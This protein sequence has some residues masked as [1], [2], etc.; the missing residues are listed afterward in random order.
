MIK[1]IQRELNNND[2]ILITKKENKFYLTNFTGSGG[3]LFISKNKTFF[4]LDGKYINQAKKQTKNIEILNIEGIGFF[5]TFEKLLKDENIKNV[6]FESSSITYSFYELLNKL[7]IKLIPKENIVEN[8]RVIKSNKEIELI[9]QSCKVA[10]S[11]ILNG[12][13]SFKSGM[14][15]KELAL[16]I[17][18]N[19]RLLNADSIDFIIVASGT[20]GSQPHIRPTDKKIN[21]GEFVTIDFG[22]VYS[23]YHSD[24]TRTFLIG[25]V[26]GV[27]KNIYQIVYEA[28]QLGISLV[29][30]GAST[31]YIDTQV[32]EFISEKGYG[33]YFVHGLG[34][35]IGING[36]EEPFLNQNC[37]TIL[38]ENMTLTIEPG[39][40]IDGVGGVRIEDT[41]VVTENGCET[42][43]KLSKNMGEILNVK[44]L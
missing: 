13:K 12:L 24:V 6:Y 11:A 26:S 31:K 30:P 43:T 42:L 37:E 25:E 40:Y 41:V 2:G 1:N 3:Y 27:L 8:L 29:K 4:L 34:H 19:A 22:I 17:E 7:N 14:S 21:T 16:N 28:Q 10:E 5:K 15:E 9:K 38:K 32:R 36:H 35:G 44:Q 23:G 33:K 18:Y 20:N 39:I